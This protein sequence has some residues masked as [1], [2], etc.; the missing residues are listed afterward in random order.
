MCQAS[1]MSLNLLFPE[2][3]GGHPT[4]GPT[5][6]WSLRELQLLEGVND[7]HRVAGYLCRIAGAEHKRPISVL[8]TGTKFGDEFFRGWPHLTLLDDRLSYRG[9]IPLSCG[10]SQGHIALRGSNDQG[11]FLSSQYVS[12]GT[13]FWTACL[14][15]SLVTGTRLPLRDGATHSHPVPRELSAAGIDPLLS[16]SLA[17]GRDSW[18]SHYEAWKAGTLSSM[19][20]TELSA[21]PTVSLASVWQVSSSKHPIAS[22]AGTT[23]RALATG[24]RTTSNPARSQTPRTTKRPLASLRPRGDGGLALLTGAQ[25]RLPSARCVGQLSFVH[26]N[27]V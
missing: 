25:R 7:A 24:Y 4:D 10:C 1:Y 15:A 17:G 11:D 16:K 19:S 22:T 13:R 5:S 27:L 14:Q 8:S 2:D 21:S 6:I 12:P 9:P 20:F 18:R 23:T 3:L 26:N